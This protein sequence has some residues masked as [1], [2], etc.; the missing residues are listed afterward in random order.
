MRQTGPEL[1]LNH[2]KPIYKLML[3]IGDN[4]VTQTEGAE[5]ERRWLE[6]EFGKLIGNKRWTRW[7]LVSEFIIKI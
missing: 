7:L 3:P 5:Q 6:G 1:A 4:I 2:N